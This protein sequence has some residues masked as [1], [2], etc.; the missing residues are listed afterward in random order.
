[1]RKTSVC[2]ILLMWG[3]IFFILHAGLAQKAEAGST[4]TITPDTGAPGTKLSIKGAG[5][6]PG[7]NVRVIFYAGALRLQLAAADSGGINTA[8]AD[9]TFILEPPGGIP[10]AKAF[11]KPGFYIVG[12]A[13]DKGS[14]AATLLEVLQKK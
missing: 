2:K 7:E 4:I 14:F 10:V 6:L 13:G 12:A 9:G 11:I 5:F 1:M 8:G 3:F